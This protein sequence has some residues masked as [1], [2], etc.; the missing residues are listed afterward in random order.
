MEACIKHLFSRDLGRT[1]ILIELKYTVPAQL[2]SEYSLVHQTVSMFEYQVS[3]IL[4]IFLYFPFSL[5]Q[6]GY[7]YIYLVSTMAHDKHPINFFY[8]C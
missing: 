2:G 5:V 8:Q 6:N 1:V 4:A 7:N 3:S